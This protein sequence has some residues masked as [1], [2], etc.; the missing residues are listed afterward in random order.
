MFVINNHRYFNRQDATYHLI[1]SSIHGSKDTAS[2]YIHDFC[3]HGDKAAYFS[4]A[5]GIWAYARQ[6]YRYLRNEHIDVIHV[7]GSSASILTEIIVAKCSRVKRII[8]HSHNT[9]SNHN[10]IHRLLRP[11]VTIL[12]DE[13]LA[14][15]NKAGHW[16]Y[17]RRAGFTVVPNGI[18]TASFRFNAA[19]RAEVRKE[20]S[21]NETQVVIGHVGYFGTVKNHILL[22]HILK[23]L[24]NEGLTNYRLI[25][26]G[27]GELKPQIQQESIDMG[28]SDSILFLGNR[29]DVPRIMMAMDLF[30]LP[31]LYEGF[32]I[33]AIEAQAAG[34]QTLISSNVSSEVCTT[35]L[36][37]QLP[38]DLGVAAW[39]K[40]IK[41]ASTSTGARAEYADKIKTAGYDIHVSARMLENKYFNK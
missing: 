6:L 19:L 14:C 29:N 7:N 27:D 4:K 37:K 25:L 35:S 38:I 40:A 17:G 22:L 26:I 31:S 28:I 18:D 39:C 10:R 20:L 12:A 32:P 1:Y 5:E 2:Y 16:M 33:V 30:C 34:L 11:F 8:A 36:V 15:G 23:A 21:I 3:R 24:K 9:Q 41:Q 13:R